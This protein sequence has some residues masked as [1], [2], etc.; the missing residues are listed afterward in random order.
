MT[1]LRKASAAI[2][3]H[4]EQLTRESIETT[5]YNRKDKEAFIT[6]VVRFTY[7]QHHGLMSNGSERLFKADSLA[8]QFVERYPD[9]GASWAS[10]EID[11][12]LDTVDFL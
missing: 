1:T 4:I 2:E 8:R 3:A 11:F 9:F 10:V 5:N 6:T 7:L 12:L